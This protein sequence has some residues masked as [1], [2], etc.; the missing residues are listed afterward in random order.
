MT[1][2][3]RI[4]TVASAK[5]GVGK[6]TLA[7]HLAGGLAARAD[8]E[9]TLVDMDWEVAGAS[10][11][12][13]HDPR[14]L[15]TSRMVTAL[16][17]GPEASPPRPRRARLRPHLV[18]THKDLGLVDVD[19]GTV[20]DC[21]LS[22]APRWGTPWIVIDTHPGLGALRDG[23]IAASDLVVVP[24]HLSEHEMLGVRDF[25][26]DLDGH[27]V[28]LVV[29]RVPAGAA[30]TRMAQQV[31]ELQGPQVAIA[32]IL[33]EYRWLP[34]RLL[35]AAL[36]LQYPD[37]PGDPP[38]AGSTRAA[39]ADFHRLAGLVAGVLEGDTP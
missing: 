36:P 28:L 12:W 29:N 9:A 25:L 18:E 35:R 4:I 31:L 17:K 37:T 30:R 27:S 14:R 15:Q 8:G 23:A 39:A 13:G 24:L 21:L 1:T 19:A 32:P 34:R 20:T 16:E 10:A 6:S 11:M 38:P 2:R 33:R 26:D 7:F 22:W 5:G 3:P